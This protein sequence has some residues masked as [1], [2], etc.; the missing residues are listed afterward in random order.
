MPGSAGSEAGATV[1]Q[2]AQSIGVG[3]D[4]VDCP[5]EGC[6]EVGP[7]GVERHRAD[8]MVGEA[9]EDKAVGN[10]MSGVAAADG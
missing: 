3:W 2:A 6:T 1:G 5:V 8:D 9:V 7:Q 10:V 4:E